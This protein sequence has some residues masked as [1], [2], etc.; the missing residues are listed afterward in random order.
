MPELHP[1]NWKYE[2]DKQASIIPS[3]HPELLSA[4]TTLWESEVGPNVQAIALMAGVDAALQMSM[5]AAIVF[6]LANEDWDRW[7]TKSPSG[8]VVVEE[9]HEHDIAALHK[10]MEAMRGDPRL[11]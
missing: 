3:R 5:G 1:E 10:T 4:L 8:L 2:H 9:G 6:A 11:G 7:A